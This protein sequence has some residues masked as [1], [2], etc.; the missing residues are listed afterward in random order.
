MWAKIRGVFNRKKMAI[1]LEV[2]GAKHDPSI[3]LLRWCCKNIKGGKRL[4]VSRM[5]EEEGTW[6][7]IFKRDFCDE[8]INGSYVDSP[9][10]P[11]NTKIYYRVAVICVDGEFIISN[12]VW[13]FIPDIDMGEDELNMRLAEC[14]VD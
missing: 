2:T 8:N 11:K 14:V 3:P 13:C 4:I 6:R 12:D 9:G 5:I 10:L 7:L 1:V